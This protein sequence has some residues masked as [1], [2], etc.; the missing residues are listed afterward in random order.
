MWSQVEHIRL[1]QRS[2]VLFRSPEEPQN[3]N[4]LSNLCTFRCAFAFPMDLVLFQTMCTAKQ[5]L[6]AQH[7]EFPSFNPFPSLPVTEIQV[8]L[9]QT[10]MLTPNNPI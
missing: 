4:V 9:Q 7:F 1:M 5:D 2:N 10:L 6:S 3:P 8:F